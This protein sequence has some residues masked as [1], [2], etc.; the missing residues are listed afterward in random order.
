MSH[1]IRTVLFIIL[2]SSSITLPAQE[3][4]Q[5]QPGDK[6][7]PKFLGAYQEPAIRAFEPRGERALETM[8]QDGKL[9]LT[10]FDAVR[11]ALESNV[12]INVERYNPYFSLW[13]VDKGRGVLN[14]SILFNTNV[15][16][17]WS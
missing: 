5:L 10:E 16:R 9:R 6:S 1:F 11:L 8:I 2:F 14:P 15:N 3:S 17:L 4:P 7:G 12:D 13:D